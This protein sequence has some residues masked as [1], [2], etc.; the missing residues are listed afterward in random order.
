MTAAWSGA[1]A[2]RLGAA[3]LTAVSFVQAGG[4][5]FNTEH[6]DARRGELDRQRSHR[7]AGKIAAASAR[8]HRS[9]RSLDDRGYTLDEE[10]D[11]RESR[12]FRGR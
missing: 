11:S 9:A 8:W 7:A 5:T 12:R 1:A 4:K 10:L 3:L 2:W 6:L